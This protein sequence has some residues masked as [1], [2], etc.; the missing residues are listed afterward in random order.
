MATGATAWLNGVLVDD[1]TSRR[2]ALVT[3]GETITHVVYEGDKLPKVESGEDLKGA[4]LLPA[5]IDVHCHFRVGDEPP[6]EGFGFGSRAA[7]AGGIA[8]AL[9]HPQATPTVVDVETFERKL[10]Q[11][12]GESFVDFGL[13]VAAVPGNRRGLDH[14][15]DA[16]ACGVKAFLCEGNPQFP[17]VSATDLGAAMRVAARHRRVVAVH[18]EWQPTLNRLKRRVD[19]PSEWERSRPIVAEVDAVEVACRLS[20]ETG[21]RLHLVHLSSARAVQCALAWRRRG[22]DVSVETCPH[23]LFLD[24]SAARRLGPFGKCMPPLRR[25]AVR[26]RLR[27]RLAIDLDI[28]ASDHAPHRLEDRA[29]GLTRFADAPSGLSTN[30]FML[31]CAATLLCE[32]LGEPRGLQRVV[33]LT[34][35]MPAKRFEIRDRGRL[36][37]GAAASFV[38]VARRRSHVRSALMLNRIQY[39][40]LEGL[41]LRYEVARTVVRGDTAYLAGE[42]VAGSPN[43]RWL[44]WP[45]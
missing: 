29:Y 43:G 12:K 26:E 4:F 5:V 21:A 38:V 7:L 32:R 15:L 13:W 35:A 28:L 20:G 44:R 23:Y 30:Q 22:V 31:P 25:H 27:D 3:R 40:P 37:P 34:A 42:G 8:T 18:A 45:Q 10:A 36:E 2:G 9:E 17:P 19:G 33:N 14:A 6:R 16:G 39:T 24:T 11:S 1:S 41:A